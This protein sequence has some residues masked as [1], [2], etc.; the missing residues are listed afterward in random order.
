[1]IAV[2]TYPVF[3]ING[4]ASAPKSSERLNILSDYIKYRSDN[5]KYR[6]NN[7]KYRSDNVKY[8]S[9]NVKYQ[10]D[11]V[12]YRSD[13]EKIKFI[14]PQFQPKLPILPTGNRRTIIN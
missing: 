7:I 3:L 13:D 12:K 1:M 6:S 9:D 10:F 8:R 2:F 4:I 5:V 11:N 14:P